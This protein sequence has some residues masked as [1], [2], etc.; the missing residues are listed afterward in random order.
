[1]QP[2][3]LPW[4]GYFDLIDQSDICVFL[5]DAQFSRQSWHQRNRIR[6]PRGLEWLTVPVQ[7]RGRPELLICEA[8]IA[9][10][11]GFPRDHIRA[12]EVHYAR[13]GHLRDYLPELQELLQ[14]RLAHLHELNMQLIRWIAGN[15]G[16]EARFEC[17]S[18]LGGQG[19]RSGL[20]L[21]ICKRVGADC[22]LSPAGASYLAEELD[23]SRTGELK[24]A[25][26]NYEHPAYRQVYDPFIPYASAVDLLFNCGAESL[27]IIRSGRNTPV[28]L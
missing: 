26:H 23:V 22:Y 21:D 15:L 20:M 27:E 5:D 7:T 1:M 3:Y 6:T 17:S 11:A 25:F 9:N 13:S 2:T 8:E 24:V 16:I 14:S 12:L 19:K 10:N 4:L 28:A 18:S